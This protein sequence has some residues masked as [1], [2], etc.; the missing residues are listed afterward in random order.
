MN[1]KE[2]EALI[3]KAKAGDADAQYM[4]GLLNILNGYYEQA[5]G[6]MRD[7][8][9]QNHPK[10][11]DWISRHKKLTDALASIKADLLNGLQI[12][13]WNVKKGEQPE[14]FG[15]NPLTDG[16]VLILARKGNAAVSSMN[17]AH[18]HSELIKEE[19]FHIMYDRWELYL[20]GK[21]MAKDIKPAKNAK[22]LISIIHYML[23]NNAE[24][25]RQ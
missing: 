25:R 19:Y 10:A 2:I 18:F 3:E 5:C 16:A 17:F 8:A 6:C 15:I 1:Q 12:K 23:E 13:V 4:F 9:K 11:L 14:E 24:L 21:L 22:Y 20:A 7:A